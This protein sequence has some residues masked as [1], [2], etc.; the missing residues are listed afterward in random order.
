MMLP[1]SRSQWAGRFIRSGD[2]RGLSP[3]F[4]VRVSSWTMLS[5]GEWEPA[6]GRLDLCRRHRVELSEVSLTPTPAQ[7]GSLV[8]AWW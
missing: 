5:P 2:M 4:A 6:L 8:R 7:P 1:D 3:G